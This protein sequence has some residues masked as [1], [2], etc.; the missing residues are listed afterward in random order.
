MEDLTSEV[1]FMALGMILFVMAVSLIIYYEH[2]FQLAY[3]KLFQISMNE[4]VIQGGTLE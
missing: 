2:S 4:Y 1:F 3:E